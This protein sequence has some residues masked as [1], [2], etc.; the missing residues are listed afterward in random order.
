[1]QGSAVSGSTG[2]LRPTHLRHESLLHNV[3][4]A[5]GHIVVHSLGGGGDDVLRRQAGYL[6]H[7][8]CR[9]A[10]PN[11]YEPGLRIPQPPCS[12]ARPV[13]IGQEVGCC[14]CPL[15]MLRSHLCEPLVLEQAIG[16]G[17]AAVLTGPVLVVGP[18]RG[19]GAACRQGSKSAAAAAVSAGRP[20]QPAR[21][22]VF[23]N[24]CIDRC[25]LTVACCTGPQPTRPPT[26]PPTHQ[27]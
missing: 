3:L 6:R 19:V 15:A 2:C 4:G 14:C 16:E 23:M 11:W 25:L 12:K 10:Q 26:H 20:M 9:M 21:A 24:R 13:G 17:V 22:S 18:Q 5:D 8:G 27:S 1:M 7:C